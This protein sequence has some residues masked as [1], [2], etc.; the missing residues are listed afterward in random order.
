MSDWN[1][2]NRSSKCY[3][4]EIA[5]LKQQRDTLL[6]ACKRFRELFFRKKG[7]DVWLANY[8]FFETAIAEAERG[9]Q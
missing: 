4:R 8:D 6:E 5:E 1:T 3:E 9:I 7:R 2:G